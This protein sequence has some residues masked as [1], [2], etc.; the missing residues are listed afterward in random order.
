MNGEEGG[1]GPNARKVLESFPGYGFPDQKSSFF[2]RAKNDDPYD[3]FIRI[4]K[5]RD[6]LRS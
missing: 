3:I 2:K 6:S 4:K 1:C 5:V